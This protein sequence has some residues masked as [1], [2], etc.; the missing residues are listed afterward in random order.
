MA[1]FDIMVKMT[2]VMKN[3]HPRTLENVI[4]ITWL[5]LV[6]PDLPALIK[7]RYGTELRSQTLASLNLKYHKPWTPFLKKYIRLMRPRF[8]V[9][10]GE[11]KKSDAFH[12]QISHNLLKHRISLSYFVP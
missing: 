11:S 5:R 6:H 8:Y 4:I 10:Q 3:W 12:I 1:V 7:Q 9:L 2:P